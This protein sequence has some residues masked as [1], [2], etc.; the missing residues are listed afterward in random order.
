M[1]EDPSKLKARAEKAFTM[2]QQARAG[3]KAMASYEEE[4]RAVRKNMARLREQRLARDAA[5]ASAP[6]EKTKAE[7]KAAEKALAPNKLNAT[8]DT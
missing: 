3:A 1:A 5:L 6:P 7:K 2:E 8:N 4:G